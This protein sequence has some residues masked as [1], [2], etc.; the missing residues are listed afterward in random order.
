MENLHRYGWNYVP[1]NPGENKSWNEKG[2]FISSYNSKVFQHQ[3]NQW[4][5]LIN[6]PAD[7]ENESLQ[8]WI[9]QPDG[10]IYCRG[11]NGSIKVNDTP[12]TSVLSKETVLAV[13]GS[14]QASL[15]IHSYY[16]DNGK[17][18]SANF[19]THSGVGT[20]SHKL[21]DI[22]NYL[23]E[24]SHSHSYNQK[25]SDCDCQCDCGDDTGGP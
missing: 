24:K 3:P 7:K 1:T 2:I 23:M 5:Q 9:N 14:T 16:N 20:A 6:I 8:I 12:F 13:S 19:G 10:A 17:H 11:G 4:G 22:I 15:N 25:V 21:I 18:V